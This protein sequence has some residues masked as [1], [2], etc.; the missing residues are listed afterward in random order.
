M[1]SITADMTWFDKKEVNIDCCYCT[2]QCKC[3]QQPKRFGIF[4]RD[5]IYL[6]EVGFKCHLQIEKDSREGLVRRGVLKY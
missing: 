1:A 6:T 3:T 4:L 2:K 5:C